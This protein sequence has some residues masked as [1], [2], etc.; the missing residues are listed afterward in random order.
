MSA[1]TLGRGTACA[2]WA[3]EALGDLLPTNDFLFWHPHAAARPVTELPIPSQVSGGHLR[4]LVKLQHGL[5][6]AT[7]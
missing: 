7:T 5:Q 6:L 4:S 1:P 2:M 3:M